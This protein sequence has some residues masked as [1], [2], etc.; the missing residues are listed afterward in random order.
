MKLA[1]RLQYLLEDFDLLGISPSIALIPRQR[2]CQAMRDNVLAA[3]IASSTG[4]KSIDY[5]KKNYMKNMPAEIDPDNVDI[6]YIRAYKS[7]KQ[8]IFKLMSKLSGKGLPPPS[9]GVFGAALVLERLPSSFFSAHLLYRLGHRYEAHA[10]SRLILEQIAWAHSAY[11]LGN[12]DDIKKIETTKTISKLKKFTPKCGILYGYLSKKTHI[13][14]SS[15]IDFLK[16]NNGENVVLHTQHQFY[17]YTQ[18]ILHLA[19]LFGIVW[20]LSQ[21]KYLPEVE[22]IKQK[23]NIYSVDECR[24]FTYIIKEHL[25]KIE[26]TYNNNIQTSIYDSLSIP[27]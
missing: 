1:E 23:D 25:N 9:N 17:E 6:E 2:S 20:E 24:P 13:D 19:D 11:E 4:L 15:H 26:T 7:A 14:Y 5:V 27:M 12:I 8:Y 22:T 21:K 16:V 3:V 10:V 18:I